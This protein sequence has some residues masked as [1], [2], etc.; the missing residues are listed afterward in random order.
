MLPPAS[1]SG[2]P[3]TST[4][5]C[6]HPEAARVETETDVVMPGGVQPEGRID[7]GADDVRYPE[8]E[9]GDGEVLVDRIEKV[10]RRLPLN[11]FERRRVRRPVQG[12]PAVKK[13][14]D[15]LR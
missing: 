10:P 5:P 6:T 8:A 1:A 9:D 4:C 3:N 11:E 13:G 2:K 12:R 15:C 7:L 14:V